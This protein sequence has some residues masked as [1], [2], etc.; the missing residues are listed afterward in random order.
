MIGCQVLQQKSVETLLVLEKDKSSS[1]SAIPEWT[2]HFGSI[3]SL[4][5]RIFAQ[6]LQLLPPSA[7][8]YVSAASMP[9]QQILEQAAQGLCLYFV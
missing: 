8:G 9:F 1:P 4:E 3:L 6:L 2:T 5:E 7:A